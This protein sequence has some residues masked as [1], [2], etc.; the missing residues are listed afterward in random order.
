MLHLPQIV[1]HQVE[2]V[3]ALFKIL[4]KAGEQR[5]HLGVFE[6]FELG[7]YVIA[8]LAR[9][10]PIHKIFQ[11]MTAQPEVIDALGKHPREKQRVIPNMFAYLALSIERRSR[12]EYRI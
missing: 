11:T 7:N 6:M 5:G 4:R 8:F 9:L 3:D 10:D 1:L 12:P 2:T